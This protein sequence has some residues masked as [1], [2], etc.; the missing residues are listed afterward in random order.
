MRTQNIYR[1]GH[2]FWWR[3][4]IS[5]CGIQIVIALPLKTANFY[6]ARAMAEQLGTALEKHRMAYSAQSKAIDPDTL[7]RRAVSA[8][9]TPP[10]F[11]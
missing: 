10:S 6:Q 5:I 11:R 7:D 9:R 4:K 3:R 1:R 2:L 8:A